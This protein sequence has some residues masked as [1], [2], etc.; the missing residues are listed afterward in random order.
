LKAPTAYSAI[1]IQNQ[2]SNWMPKYLLT[3]W[4]LTDNNKKSL[5]RLGWDGSDGITSCHA[6]GLKKTT[7]LYIAENST[8]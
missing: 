8:K 2:S 4:K 3:D 6:F 7:T 1:E 5:F